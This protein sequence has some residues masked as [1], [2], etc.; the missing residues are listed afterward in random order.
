[1]PPKKVTTLVLT[2]I[3]ACAAAAGCSGASSPPSG[4]PPATSA[5]TGT[6]R[7]SSPTGTRYTDGTYSATG[8]YGSGPS[9]IDVTVTLTDGV[10]T[11][12]TVGPQ[13][14]NPTSLDYQNRFAAAVPAVV[15]G[16]PIDEVNVSHLAGSSGTPDGFNAAIEQ[17]KTK[18]AA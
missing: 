10:I 18:A 14:T 8:Q 17:I 5:P 4:L 16:R 1:M 3:A 15:V 13:A 7:P 2:G 6:S 11:A 12:V 9:F